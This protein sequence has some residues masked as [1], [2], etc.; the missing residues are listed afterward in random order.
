[1]KLRFRLPFVIA[2]LLSAV[3]QPLPAADAPGSKD[4]AIFKRMEGSE[5]IWY[6]K[7]PSTR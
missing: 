4:P 1:M 5:I 3:S 7:W 6:K 2:A